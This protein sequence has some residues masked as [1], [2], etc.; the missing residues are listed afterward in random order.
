M[1]VSVEK[2]SR[3]VLLMPRPPSVFPTCLS[4]PALPLQFLA[5]F[6]SFYKDPFVTGSYA[7]L[8][9]R[10][11]RSNSWRFYAW[12]WNFYARNCSQ[13]VYVLCTYNHW[14]MLQ[15]TNE[16]LPVSENLELF[17]QRTLTAGRSIYSSKFVFLSKNSK[18][19]ATT[20]TATQEV[21]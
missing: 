6:Y 16:R 12:K 18:F 2:F 9:F 21:N 14:L 13:T 19:I 7:K 20:Q 10:C 4:P 8:Q 5:T 17:K 3:F 1:N 15:Y 11:S